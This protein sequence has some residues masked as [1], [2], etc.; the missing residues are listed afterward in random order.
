MT[1]KGFLVLALILLFGSSA[2]AAGDFGWV[3][4]FNLRA[5]ADPTGFRA[6]LAARFQIGEAQITAVL[7][8]V[9]SPAD[10]YLVFR[11]GEMSRQPTDYVLNI[12]PLHNQRDDRPELKGLK[13]RAFT[14]NS[15]YAE[16]H[17]GLRVN[18]WAWA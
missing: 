18:S 14:L 3:T 9:P 17:D 4:D 5:Y 1:R 10:A 12:K 2:A 11:L 6:Q 15:F 7:G 16:A 8:N 13:S